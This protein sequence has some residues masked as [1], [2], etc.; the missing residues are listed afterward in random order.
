MNPNALYAR[1]TRLQV[2]ALL[3]GIAGLAVSVVGAFS[4]TRQFFMAG[5]AFWRVGEPPHN[6]E[7]LRADLR[8][9]GSDGAFEKFSATHR[10]GK[11]PIPHGD[12]STYGDH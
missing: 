2:N 9:S 11:F 4:N 1:L 7:S 5:R 10:A 3:I 6:V 8:K 12:F